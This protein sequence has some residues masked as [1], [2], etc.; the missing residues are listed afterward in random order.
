VGGGIAAYVAYNWYISQ[1]AASQQQ[2]PAADQTG[3]GQIADQS[4]QQQPMLDPMVPP[5]TVMQVVPPPMMPPPSA[6][7]LPAAHVP[8]FAAWFANLPPARKTQVARMTWPQKQNA[9]RAFVAQWRAHYAN[10]A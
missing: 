1:Q 7:A 9:Y 10:A 2:P 3:Q 6:Y 8:L 5:S 4:G